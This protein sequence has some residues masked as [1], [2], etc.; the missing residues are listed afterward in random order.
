MQELS[1]RP[2]LVVLDIGKV[3]NGDD[4]A[5]HFAL[6]QITPFGRFMWTH[7]S[8]HRSKQMGRYNLVSEQMLQPS[9]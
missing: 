3:E 9:L 5:I 2:K 4:V 1:K 7:T 8:G 6:F